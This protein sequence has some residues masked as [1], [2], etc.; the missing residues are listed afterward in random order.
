[1]SPTSE[2]MAGSPIRNSSELRGLCRRSYFGPR[3][4]GGEIPNIIEV[5]GALNQGFTFS[6]L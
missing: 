3:T 6:P 4:C 2:V 1:M 5:S